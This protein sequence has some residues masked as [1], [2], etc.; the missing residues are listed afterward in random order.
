MRLQREIPPGRPDHFKPGG[1][2]A[3]AAI[4]RQ[5]SRGWHGRDRCEAW[6]DQWFGKLRPPRG[7]IDHEG[8]DEG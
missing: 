5:L 2:R 3:L 7:A 1:A 6:Q 4:E 8:I